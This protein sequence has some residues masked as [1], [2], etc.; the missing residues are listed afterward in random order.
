MKIF[1]A[2]FLVLGFNHEMDDSAQVAIADV[3]SDSPWGGEW[4]LIACHASTPPPPSS[5]W[6]AASPWATT[7]QKRPGTRCQKWDSQRG[8][9]D[10]SSSEICSSFVKRWI[11]EKSFKKKTLP[12]TILTITIRWLWLVVARLVPPLLTT[13]PRSGLGPG[14]YFWRW[15]LRMAMIKKEAKS[16]IT[17]C[18]DWGRGRGVTLGGELWGRHW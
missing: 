5:T 17:P 14:S 6:T 3:W 9:G 15:T 18:Q 10:Q 16:K 8:K 11:T 7:Y 4:P 2:S 1:H 12:I 13:W